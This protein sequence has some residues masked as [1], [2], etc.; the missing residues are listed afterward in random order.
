[1]KLVTLASFAL[2]TL[3]V[4]GVTIKSCYEYD[5][6]V[7]SLIERAQ[8]SADREDMHEQLVLLRTNFED[9][10]WTTGHFAV[11]WKTPRNDLSLHYRAIVRLIE[12]LE[13]ISE[14]PKS[15]VAY[16]TALDDIRGTVREIPN[17]GR[18]MLWVKYWWMWTL[19]GLAGTVLWFWLTLRTPRRR[20]K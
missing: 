8:I 2:V 20:R 1:M 17:P 16:Q 12:R 13:A 7:D 4:S 3:L 11:I 14:L 19:W 5:T 10:G 6:R 15:D 18:P 9:L